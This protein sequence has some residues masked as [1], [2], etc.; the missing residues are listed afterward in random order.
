MI[1]KAH[2]TKCM[3]T[4]LL[5]TV[6][7]S[8]I[9]A[10]SGRYPIQNF[11]PSDYQA[12]IQNIDFA[13][14]RDMQ[15]FVANNLG[16]LSFD[17][18]EWEVHADKTGKKHRSLMFD[19]TADR[20]YTGSQGEF[21]Y[22]HGNWEYVPL[23]S[24]IPA[25][26]SNF[27]DVW[28]IFLVDGNVYFCTLQNI[29][30]YDGHQIEVISHE[31]GFGRSFYIS[32]SLFT[33][34]TSG[35]IYEVKGLR[36]EPT[37]F[38][39]I[40]EVLAGLVSI[41]NGYLL[42]YNSGQV[43]FA[44]GLIS[45]RHEE[46]M[47]ALKGTY[48][49]HVFQLS[50]GR[51]VISTQRQ[52][53]FLYNLRNGD[54][55]RITT[56]EGLQSNACLNTYQDFAGN[57]WVGQQSGI[58]IVYINSPM[59]L[60]S[61]E[62][63]LE[64]SGYESYKGPQG[65]YFTTSN[66][67]YFLSIKETVAQF[68]AG[69][70]GPAYG[71][72]QIGSKVYAGHHNGLYRL[73]GNKATLVTNTNGLWQIKQLRSH[74]NYV[75]GGTYTGL[76]LF[77]LDQSE[78]LR[79]IGRISGFDESSRF[80]EE[81]VNGNLLVSQ[82]Y[83]GVFHVSL[84]PDLLDA[85]AIQLSDTL[86]GVALRQVVLGKVDNR[87][88]LGTPSGIYTLNGTTDGLSTFSSLSNVIGKQ[89]VY[90]IQQDREKNIHVIAEDRV[91]FFKQ[92]SANNYS[93][94]PSSLYQLRYELNT[95]LLSASIDSEEGVLFSANQGFM[96]YLPTQEERAL[97]QRPL[98]IRHVRNISQ[99]ENI[100]H[101]EPFDDRPPG[102]E[103]IT[104]N[105]QAKALE[106]GV[107]S[108]QFTSKNSQRF[109]YFLQGFDDEFSN[110]TASPYKEYTNL[111]EG[112][113]VLKVQTRNYLGEV[114]EG[115]PLNLVVHP[116][117]HRSLF[118]KI[119]YGIAALLVL[120]FFSRRQRKSYE[121][122]AEA[123]EQ[124]QK[125]AID[126]EQQKRRAIEEQKEKELLEL[127]EEK[128]ENELRHIN[129]LLAASTMN[130]VVKNEF[131]ETI[132]EE[133]REIRTQGRDTKTRKAL[134]KIEREIDS[135]LRLQEDWQQFEYHFDK[136]HGDFLTRIREEFEDLTP[137]DQKLC[138]FLRL[139]LS[140][141]EIANLM[142]ISLRGAEIARYRLRMKLNLQKGQNLSKYILEY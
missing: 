74:P 104:L 85:Q 138:A 67:I 84:S 56:A 101:Q 127:E 113:Y 92:I 36:L 95:D 50:D 31:E 38:I 32:G 45:P 41:D 111:S 90:L 88:C 137:N 133:L 122:Q 58:S 6:K 19:A 57:L 51:L 114:Q 106:I 139:N 17:G 23:T 97:V 35:Q 21:G 135:T 134:E 47:E 16:V 102:L 118:A 73:D 103:D 42:I 142:S 110:W 140:T 93:F 87:I 136:V 3:V 66:G 53:L 126:A 128:M 141:K 49:N 65:T 14:N 26:E 18:C 29:F 7:W 62:L 55:E 61:H 91:G 99:S 131:I 89:P 5:L 22:F 34:T 28:D 120:A 15:V 112:E 107:E 48:V 96:R 60:I 37:S 81:D 1:V 98:L 46:L 77:A 79:G 25:S 40:N 94:V 39:H 129:N 123:L 13:Q 44:S 100:Y 80:F 8:I 12:G 117:F 86:D 24:L 116:P 69:T 105:R 68:M 121:M 27:D 130:L 43:E 2:F 72:T 33:Q 63:G 109:R 125:D 71:L 132:K 124:Q 119:L 9:D 4:C 20:L 54:L 10:S 64:G 115:L 83:K 52:G 11:Y 78:A 82:Y 76:H 30:R 108:F 59:R 70:E 75:I